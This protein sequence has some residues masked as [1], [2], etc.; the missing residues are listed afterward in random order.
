MNLSVAELAT[1]WNLPMPEIADQIETVAAR[2]LAAPAA[3]FVDARDPRTLVLGTGQRSDGT[4]APIG[5]SYDLLR[6]VLWV[7]APMGRG[8]S[9]WLKNLFA[10]LLRAGAGFM[11]LDCKGTDLVQGTLPLIP[12]DREGDVAILDLGGVP[13]NGEH[14]FATMNLLA[15]D[16]GRALGVDY[17]TQASTV[18]SFFATLDDRFDGAPAVQNFATM[19]MLALMEGEPQATM[20]HLVRFY[21]DEDYRAE[22]CARLTNTQVQDFWLSRFPLMTSQDTSA[23]TAFKRRIDLLLT[24][25]AI[26]AMSV[27]PGCSINLRDLMDHQG[28][29]L[30]GISAK[31][32]KIASIAATLLLTQMTLA[33]LSRTN[34]P[35]AQR[36]DWPVVIDEAQIVFAKNPGMAPVIFSQLRAMR[37]GTVV[38][39]QN[40][41]QLAAILSVLMGNAQSRLILGAEIEDATSYGTYYGALGLAKEDFLQ[42]ERFTHAYLKLYGTEALL[43]SARMPP[44]VPPLDEP[45]PQREYA[46]WRTVRAV[47][48]SA[49]DQRLDATIAQFK[50]LAVLDANTAVQ[51]LGQLALRDRAAYDA[52]CARTQAHRAAQRRFLLAHPGCLADKVQRIR[53]LSALKIGVPRIE[54][55]ALQWALLMQSR[56]AAQARTA[57][58]AAEKATTKRSKAAKQVGPVEGLATTPPAAEVVP[59]TTHATLPTLEQLLH[60]RGV[61]RSSADERAPGFE[62]LE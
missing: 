36:R 62:D 9:E 43:F 26:A 44:L 57:R 23:L 33:A 4:W 19:G 56:A 37:I 17:D 22:V 50:E 39:H 3:A 34:V 51:R 7:T 25:P 16:F 35:E 20:L 28:I 48:R 14:L 12:L 59:A 2:W 53:T 58:A 60:E 61:R 1:L 49:A 47:A 27:A 52:Y 30:A 10:G 31:D 6:Y 55:L 24:Y 45:A 15:G 21:D 11:A 13:C 41:A 46:N 32:G 29:L 38:V 5:L 8:K 18:L 42:M 54:T 40:E